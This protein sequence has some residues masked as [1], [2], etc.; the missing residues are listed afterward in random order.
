M[1]VAI[2]M[3]PYHKNP[4]TITEDQYKLL[5]RDLKKLGDLSGIVH[6][7]NSGETIGGNQRSKVFDINN[8]KIEI[9]KKYKTPTRT[10]TIAEGFVIWQGERYTYRRVRWTK[11]QCEKA[12]IVANKAGGNWDFDVLAN[13]FDIDDLTDWGFQEWE[14]GVEGEQEPQEKEVDENTETKNECPKCG[15]K[16]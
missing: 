13:E 10:G 15:Y 4:R 3:K 8:C 14:F 7:V 5:E 1:V 9:T 11:K 16:W 12:N 2:I 6:D